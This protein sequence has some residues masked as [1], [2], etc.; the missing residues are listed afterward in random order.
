MCIRRNCLCDSAVKYQCNEISLAIGESAWRRKRIIDFHYTR[1]HADRGFHLPI[2]HAGNDARLNCIK[3][4]IRVAPSPSLD[5]RTLEQRFHGKLWTADEFIEIRIE[6]SWKFQTC[7][8]HF[9]VRN[10]QITRGV[11]NI[12]EFALVNLHI[13]YLPEI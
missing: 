11:F 1:S 7:S 6:S 13:W 3:Q 8:D 12:N 4:M 5:R 2:Y 9:Y 10:Y